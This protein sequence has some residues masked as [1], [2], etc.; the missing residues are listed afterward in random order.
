MSQ[1]SHED[2]K[3]CGGNAVD[4]TVVGSGYTLCGFL[5]GFLRNAVEEYNINTCFGKLKEPFKGSLRK[6]FGHGNNYGRIA[7][8][9]EGETAV[10]YIG[11]CKVIGGDDVEVDVTHGQKL[12]GSV[13]I[14]VLT[15]RPFSLGMVKDSAVRPVYAVG[16]N[17]G[18]A[19]HVLHKEAELL[20]LGIVSGAGKLGGNLVGEL[21]RECVGNEVVDSADKHM[22]CQPLHHLQTLNP[23]VCAVDLAKGASHFLILNVRV[24][25][26]K[27]RKAEVE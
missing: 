4:V 5:A 1:L 18:H 19:V 17:G 20:F 24:R 12:C 13:E 6:V 2:D 8:A 10:L 23:A 11:L 27:L 9:S 21:C 25:R 16:H 3:I 7:L 15:A 22:V 26:R 14:H